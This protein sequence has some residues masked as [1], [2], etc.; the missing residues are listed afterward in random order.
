MSFQTLSGPPLHACSHRMPITLDFSS[1]ALPVQL[2]LRFSTPRLSLRARKR[3]SHPILFAFVFSLPVGRAAGV[4]A[5]DSCPPTGVSLCP[6]V[7]TVLFF[8]CPGAIP[9][10]CRH[11]VCNPFLS[12]NTIP[13]PPL[14]R[15]LLHRVTRTTLLL[16]GQTPFQSGSSLCLFAGDAGFACHAHGQLLWASQGTSS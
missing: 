12:S 16:A 11:P 13:P 10:P 15:S 5:H 4:C 8:H 14:L 9:C 3:P 6:L 1:T 2:R 7:I